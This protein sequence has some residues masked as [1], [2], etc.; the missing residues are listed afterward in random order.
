MGLPGPR[1]SPG[2]TSLSGPKTLTIYKGDKVTQQR[3][4]RSEGF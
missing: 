1:G 4:G 2:D 3:K